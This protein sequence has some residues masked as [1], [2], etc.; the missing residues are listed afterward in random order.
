MF[1]SAPS[2]TQADVATGKV[3]Q[4]TG[5]GT[6]HLRV[7][8]LIGLPDKVRVG[9]TEIPARSPYAL[10]DNRLTDN[11]PVHASDLPNF[12]R[13]EDVDGTP[14]L[15]RSMR[16]NDGIWQAGA[17]IAVWG[18]WEADADTGQAVDLP[19]DLAKLPLKELRRIAASE[20]IADANNLSKEALIA[21][22]T[23]DAAAK[24]AAESELVKDQ[25]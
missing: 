3:R 23:A 5:S 15:L 16:S 10:P 17:P 12:S 8:G 19:G 1:H 18:D 13:T 6:P 24:T 9:A 21:A 25:V 20:A 22:I 11:R 7:P 14:L 2:V 4:F